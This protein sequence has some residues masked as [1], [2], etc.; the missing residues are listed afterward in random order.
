MP[1]SATLPPLYCTYLPAL[2]EH[3]RSFETFAKNPSILPGFYSAC[4]DGA[5]WLEYAIPTV[6]R[7]RLKSLDQPAYVFLYSG[8]DA[9]DWYGQPPHGPGR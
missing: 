2:S 5:R 3:I 4:G 8:Y 7:Q 6:P 9:S 1:L